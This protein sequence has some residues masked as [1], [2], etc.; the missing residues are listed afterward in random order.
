MR[1]WVGADR[2]RPMEGVPVPLRAYVLCLFAC[3]SLS[4]VVKDEPTDV[5]HRSM[6]S[7]AAGKGDVEPAR[8]DDDAGSPQV[9]PSSGFDKDAEGWTIV[10]DAQG[11]TVKPDF[12][13]MGGNPGGLITAKDDV[14]G[15]TFYFVAPS[16]YLGDQSKAYAKRLEFDLKTTSLNVPFKAYGVMLSGG[17]VTVI[18]MLPSDPDPIDTWKSYA[19]VLDATGGWKVVAGTDITADQSFSDAPAA[20]ERDLR[21]VLGALT[22]FRIRGEFNTGADEGSLDNV[23]FGI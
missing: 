8:Q 15:G 19:F 7:S 2:R 3:L 13:G 1:R 23:H 9:A 10:G 5:M 11:E 20:G 6:A 22:T 16:K 12:N 14:T 18:A 4:C 17:G 21:S